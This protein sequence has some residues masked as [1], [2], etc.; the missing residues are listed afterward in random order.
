[1]FWL[2]DSCQI[3]VSADQYRLTVS[4]AQVSSHWVRVFF[5]VIRWQ[6]A[7]FQ[8]IAGSSSIFF[9]CIWNKSCSW[10]VRLRSDAKIQLA[11][12]CREG[13]RFWL[14]SQKSRVDHTLRSIF[15]L[16]LVKIWQVS[17]CEK[18]MQRLE[19]CLLTAEA[20]R[21]LCHLVIF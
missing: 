14:F 5:E 6:V 9:K 19:T 4:R 20:G 7:S 11:F 16:W 1:M 17:S 12:T 8:M 10:A 3:S 2:I 15:T 21:I 13:N 18:F